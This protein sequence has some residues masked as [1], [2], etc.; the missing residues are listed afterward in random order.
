MPNESICDIIGK[1][2]IDRNER[3]KNI[4]EQRANK[5]RKLPHA[6]L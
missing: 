2:K 3:M 6:W 5:N 1:V 4:N